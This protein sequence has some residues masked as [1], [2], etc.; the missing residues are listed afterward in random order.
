M[1][2]IQVDGNLIRVQDENNETYEMS[3]KSTE[4]ING[5]GSM[6]KTEGYKVRV[7]S[8]CIL[9]I[10]GQQI[11][12]PMTIDIRRGW[13]IISFPIN[14]SVDA[15]QVIQPLIDN[16]VLYKIQDEK[17]NSIENWRG[18]G[19][20]NGI[21][22]FIAGEGYIL[23]ANYD[24]VLTINNVQN[25]SAKSVASL[26]ERQEASYFQVSYV[27]NGVNHMNI[28]IAELNKTNLRPGDEIAVFDG[29]ICVG[30]IKLMEMDFEN[31]AISIPAS[32]SELSKLDGFTDGNSI[33]IK[34]WKNE[35]NE[36]IKL[37]SELIEGNL[38]FN[39][40]AS[41][42]LTLNFQTTNVTNMFN[43]YTVSMFPNP[44]SNRF[45]VKFSAFPETGTKIT[46]LNATG[47]ELNSR[48]A[49]N[50]EEV[51]E[52]HDLPGGIYFVKTEYNNNYHTQ[53]LIKR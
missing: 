43:D 17:G 41:V 32:A 24:G 38:V 8:D 47:R 1:K 37:L 7:N 18:R 10:T 53:K 34:A 13:N 19:W 28:N 50:S 33:V 20:S 45:T 27:G 49:Q 4:W 31:N 29:S 3:R 21:G 23:Q 30:S 12:L 9:E 6:Q 2:P 48:F 52:I 36:E 46:L 22:D 39:K 35:T 40:Q 51:F 26:Q 15:M 14:G 5:I 44:A 42:F 16:G 11:Q 25:K